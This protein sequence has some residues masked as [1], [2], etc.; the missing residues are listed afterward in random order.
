MADTSDSTAPNGLLPHGW[1]VV[2]KPYGMNST[3]VVSLLKRFLPRKYKIGHAGTLDPLATGI[4]PLAI[5]EATKTIA[6]AM[7]AIKT[8]EF[9]ITWGQSRD[10]EDAE[11][12]ITA[13]SDVRPSADDIRSVLPR[14]IGTI[15]QMPPIYSALKVDGKR[16]YD[17]A[18]AGEEVVLKARPVFIESLTLT[19]YES[20]SASFEV[21]C[22]KGTYV[23]SLARDIAQAVG[24]KGYVSILRRTRVG[25]FVLDQSK[26]DLLERAEAK[27]KEKTTKNPAASIGQSAAKCNQNEIL[28]AQSSKGV[29]IDEAFVNSLQPL[30]MVLDDIPVISIDAQQAHALSHGQRIDSLASGLTLDLTE[31]LYRAYWGSY[32]VALV[33]PDEGR[34]RPVRVFTYWKN[35]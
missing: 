35:L 17:L 7:D 24:A 14:F 10:T 28:L 30:D 19:H 1:I 21:V 9:T 32:C 15:E 12:A 27:K 34:I 3:R 31:N 5:G 2:D 18:R 29:Y 16:A 4:L 25:P 11:G 22:G 33:R 13:T 23:R 6:F 26:H 8:Y 20:E